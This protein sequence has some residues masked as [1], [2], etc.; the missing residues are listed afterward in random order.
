MMIA[1]CVGLGYG[2]NRHIQQYVSYI[3]ADKKCKK[4]QKGNTLYMY[5]YN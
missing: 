2:V 1:K 4:D 5:M 3:E